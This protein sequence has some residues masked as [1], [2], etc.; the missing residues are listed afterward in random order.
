MI[1]IPMIT[2]AIVI[3]LA[4]LGFR[5]ITSQGMILYFLRRP[6]DIITENRDMNIKQPK[7]NL[8]IL[9]LA[10]PFITCVTCMASIHTLIWYYVIIGH[11]S[12]LTIPVMLMVAFINT[13]AW[14]AYQK[15][16]D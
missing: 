11:Y 14:E 7:Y 9:Y 2:L 4:T 12:T 16:M 3:S 6:F 1:M 5:A 13:I 15:L 8:I 10:K